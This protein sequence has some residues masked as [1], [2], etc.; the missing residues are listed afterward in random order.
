MAV[1]TP[2]EWETAVVERQLE[3]LSLGDG[4]KFKSASKIEQDQYLFLRVLWPNRRPI[5]HFNPTALGLPTTATADLAKNKDWVSLIDHAAKGFYEII[6]ERYQE[7]IVAGGKSNEGGDET[8]DGKDET[9]GF[10]PPPATSESP[11]EEEIRLANLIQHGADSDN[12]ESWEAT[13]APQGPW[14]SP[15]VR[16]PD[17][18]GSYEE[19]EKIDDENI[20]NIAL[21]LLLQAVCLRAPDMGA[22]TWTPQRKAFDFK[23]PGNGK[24][25]ATDLFSAC[26]DGH[27]SLGTSDDAPSLAIIEVQARDRKTAD[28]RMQESAQMAAW[29]NSQPDNKTKSGKYQRLMISQDNRDCFLIIA[30]YDQDYVD[31]IL[32]NE[33]GKKKIK[34]PF[35]SMQE[36]G[37]FQPGAPGH[38]KHLCYAILAFTQQLNKYA[39]KGHPC[40]WTLS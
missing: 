13:P 23:V 21:I 35:M 32:Q 36:Y 29:I 12:E 18:S 34:K 5:E 16:E 11:E 26:V 39:E 30:E 14:G 24:A 40:R 31:Y 7:N 27:L 25:K 19:Y 6:G 17:E 15:L 22:T 37:P 28:P 33:V 8:E 38:I 9:T 10:Q 4:I 3:D 1:S 20:V 2:G